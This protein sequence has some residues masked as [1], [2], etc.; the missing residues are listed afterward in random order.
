MSWT[1]GIRIAA[2]GALLAT[3][4]TG[5]IKKALLDGQIKGTRDGSAAVNT[6]HDYEV[7]KVVARAGMGQLEGMHRLAPDNTNALFMLLRGWTGM[8][9]GFTEDEY[10]LA[11]EK[12]DDIQAEYHRSRARAGYNRAIYYG[13]ELL[14]HTAEGFDQ[15]L[16]NSD[17]INK[18]LNENFTDAEDAETLLWFGLAWIGRVAVSTDMPELVAELFVAK[19]FLERSIKLDENFSYGMAHT[20]LGAYHARSAMAEL[21][22]SKE[23]FDKALAINGG[24]YLLTKVLMADRYYCAKHDKAGY[25]KLLNEVLAAPDTIPEARLQNTIAKRRARRFLGNPL[26]QDACGFDYKG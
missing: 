3:T 19:A 6:L 14:A 23:H 22:E 2:V 26:W 8:T 1:R 17:T 18:W 15:S 13:K 11:L 9:S 21:D 10:Q 5:C 16:K 4:T 7:A 20:V 25:F 12:G 24:K